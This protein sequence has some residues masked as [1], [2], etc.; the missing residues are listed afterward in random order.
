[1]NNVYTGNDYNTTSD[2]NNKTDIKHF[3]LNNLNNDDDLQHFIDIVAT[4]NIQN[5]KKSFKNLDLQVDDDN[6]V[7][8]KKQVID[9]LRLADAIYENAVTLNPKKRYLK[10]RRTKLI[11][12]TITNN[13]TSNNNN[14]VL[15]NSTLTTDA[16]VSMVQD[17]VAKVDKKSTYKTPLYNLFVALQN[18]FSKSNLES[19]FAMYKNYCAEN[20]HTLGQDNVAFDE[21]VQD[22]NVVSVV[23]TKSNPDEKSNTDKTNQQQQSK[24]I[25]QI[26][27][28][29]NHAST[30]TPPPPPPPISSALDP[31]GQPPM[32]KIDET[33]IVSQPTPVQSVVEPVESKI[34][35]KNAQPNA[36]LPPTQPF[37][38]PSEPT[39]VVDGATNLDLLISTPP[40]P[41][42]P[43]FSLPSQETSIV[44]PPPTMLMP[45]PPP[46]PA[47][48][49]M[50]ND[51]I[52]TGQNTTNN[53][54]LK[55]TSQSNNNSNTAVESS[56]NV[57]AQIAKGVTLKKAADRVVPEKPV[58]NRNDLM[59][60]IAKGV[61]LKKASDRIIPTKSSVN[62]DQKKITT[63]DILSI[64]SQA[65]QSHR[66]NKEISSENELTSGVSD[67]DWNEQKLNERMKLYQ[68]ML[69]AK[70][71]LITNENMLRNDQSAQDELQIV[72]RIAN[73]PNVSNS[74]DEQFDKAATILDN[75]QDKLVK[76]QGKTY[77]NLLENPIADA[78]PLYE[79][80]IDKFKEALEN[81]FNQKKLD[82][83]MMFIETAKEKGFYPTPI[84]N[85]EKNIKNVLEYESYLKINGPIVKDKTSKMYMTGFFS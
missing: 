13:V 66:A 75:L 56:N 49:T 30:I 60:Q 77:V 48:P 68:N 39:N 2:Y 44:P 8:D 42:P 20:T 46:P 32:E 18:N 22:N 10:K 58:P 63:P 69:R 38:K 9:L 54:L 47:P 17:M 37:V 19:F 84:Q 57:I 71:L 33:P 41:P 11:S 4:P 74:S 35:N 72:S 85:L 73:D 53:D 28:N 24:P 14:A 31:M 64:M 52:E 82:L 16:L 12:T 15:T 81:L 78:K 34:K 59:Q 5:L 51:S 76:K 70:L 7:L 45:P 79:T 83:A 55:N 25:L 61:V 36:M 67:V 3:V 80:D 6:V 26:V 1:M 23:E 62:V 21:I 43:P 65:M 29:K 40:P 27:N 50:L